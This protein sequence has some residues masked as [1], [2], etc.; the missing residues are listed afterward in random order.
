V[1]GGRLSQPRH[2]KK[3][4]VARAKD[5]IDIAMAAVMYITACGMIRTWIL[6]HRRQVCHQRNLCKQTDVNNLL[7]GVARQR[8]AQ[9]LIS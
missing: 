8:T 5:C 9:H 2:C 6:S 1:D 3:G 4:A 7:K